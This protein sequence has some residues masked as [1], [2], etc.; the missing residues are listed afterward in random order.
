[1]VVRTGRPDTAERVDHYST[2]KS[3][4]AREERANL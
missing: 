4:S 2:V 3:T 1:V